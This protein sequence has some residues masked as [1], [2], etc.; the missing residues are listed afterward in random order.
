MV[1][2]LKKKKPADER[3][4]EENEFWIK[5]HKRT[6]MFPAMAKA[7]ETMRAQG[8]DTFEIIDYLQHFIKKLEHEERH[9]INITRWEQ[10]HGVSW[11][12]NYEASMNQD[13]ARGGMAGKIVVNRH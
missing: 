7:V 9:P 6:R 11:K 3:E 12:G 1:E 8:N 2:E 13:P 4:K 5:Y 10:V